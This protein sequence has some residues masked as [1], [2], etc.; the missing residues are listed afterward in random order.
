M[1]GADERISIIVPVYNAGGYIEETI[2]MVEAQTFS[3]WELIL[4]DDC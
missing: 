3:D 2:R 1:S 4:V